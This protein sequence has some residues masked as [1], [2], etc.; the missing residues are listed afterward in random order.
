LSER[1]PN[2]TK[3][4]RSARLSPE[5]LAKLREER[6]AARRARGAQSLSAEGE[7]EG[8]PEEREEPIE[9]AREAGPTHPWRAQAQGDDE[10]QTTSWRAS[11]LSP[12]E[13]KAREEERALRAGERAEKRAAKREKATQDWERAHA[14]RTRGQA[15]QERR[16]T[17]RQV[18]RSALSDDATQ[19]PHVP[20][21]DQRAQREARGAYTSKRARPQPS[22]GEVELGEGAS[23]ARD[24]ER[25]GAR[26]KER[27][28]GGRRQKKPIDGAWLREA[29]LRYLGRFPA[30]EAHFRKVMHRKIRDAESRVS[31][32]PAEHARWVDVAV[33]YARQYGGLNDEQ[34]ARSLINSMRRQG[35]SSAMIRR[36]LRVKGLDEEQ[37][38]RAFEEREEER[39]PELDQLASAARAARKKRIGPWGPSGLDYPARQKQL[40]ALA[41]RGFSFGVAKRVL[42]A[43][44][45]VAEEWANSLN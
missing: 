13:T 22:K 43:E 33:E 14:R 32:E 45:E 1:P 37:V 7:R 18:E 40:A 35:L 10:P 24:E 26:A 15:R 19:E 16:P 30:S 42:D 28:R 25:S 39:D 20:R 27:S 44:L 3:S 38:K 36:K 11:K 2:E 29:G 4:W 17:R 31:E 5:E 6:Q 12:N 41:R 21:G 23:R 8:S 9:Q 34:L